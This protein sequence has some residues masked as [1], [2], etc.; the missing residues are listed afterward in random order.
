MIS[1]HVEEFGGLRVRDFVPAKGIFDPKNTAYRIAL[2]YDELQ[3][4]GSPFEDL[5]GQFLA[6]PN[7]GKVL[8]LVIGQWGDSGESSAGVV[9]ILTS[10]RDKLKSLT[11]LFVGDILQSEQE[12]SWITQSD[13]SPIWAAFPNLQEFHIRGGA[14]LHLGTIKHAALHSL[15][16]ETGGLRREV[17]AEV[18]NSSLPALQHLELWL[19]EEHYGGTATVDDLRPFLSADLFPKLKTLA[20]R[21]FR[22]A[23][24][25]ARAIATAPVLKKIDRLDLS[26]GTLGD[27]GGQALLESP[28]IKRLKKLDLHHHYM[29]PEI[30][31]SLRRLPIEVDVS[32]RREPREGDGDQRY[33][34]VSE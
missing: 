28:R 33:V 15:V 2:D 12:I 19:G 17:V 10:A 21:N 5:F 6:D 3:R 11:G 32:D 24:D 13:L 27:E 30:T 18:A 26:L 14:G 29:S 7:I 22:F 20:L 23:D 8:K 9:E 25:L 4:E 1:S 16:V 31:D 34:A